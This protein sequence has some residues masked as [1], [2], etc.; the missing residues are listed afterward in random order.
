VRQNW[1]IL[2]A[3]RQ[4]RDYLQ[5]LDANVICAC[6]R[7]TADGCKIGVDDHLAAGGSLDELVRVLH[8]DPANPVLSL[9]N[10][11]A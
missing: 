4:L 11:Y 2:N 5:Y 1:Q 3:M 6:P 8:I 9:L 10:N 7:P